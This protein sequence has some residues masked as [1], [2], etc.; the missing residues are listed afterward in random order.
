MRPV[1]FNKVGDRTIGDGCPTH[2]IAE[3]ACAHEGKPDLAHR[4]VNIAAEAR[5]DAVQLQLFSVERL[6][7]PYHPN[8]AGASRLEI[9]LTE[10]PDIIAH[11]KQRGLHVWA[12]V[13]DEDAL[14]LAMNEDVDALKLHSSDLSNPR[15]LDAVGS[16]GKPVSLAVGGSTLDE[17]SH[18][19]FRLRERGT[20]G[21]ILMHGYQGYPT[22]P[23][24]S[25]LGFI[26]TL[27]RLFNCPV[28]YQ[29]HTDGASELA[30]ILPLVAIGM[31]ACVLEKHYT[32]NRAR[33][34]TDYEA[35]LNPQDLARF[36]QLVRETDAAIGD[37]TVQPMSSAEL[38]YRRTMKKTIVAARSI[39]KGETF[40]ENML[41]FMRAGAGLMPA[42]VTKIIGRQSRHD[43]PQFA[44]IT[45]L[46]LLP[47]EEGDDPPEEVVE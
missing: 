45:L 23:Q 18:A 17:I 19:V 36:V 16:T 2:I 29:D 15:M 25:R 37:G 44:A 20:A 6:V 47:V 46:D 10:W 3:M 24:D 14:A 28:G 32:D 33:R 35:A 26:E 12:N 7:S 21:L 1:A 42:E 5:V 13:F 40:T 11:A 8:Y 30:V 39:T 4:L 9:P 22:A 34:G 38:K 43:I 27:R 41:A 31:G